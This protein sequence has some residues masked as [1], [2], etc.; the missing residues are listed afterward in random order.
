MTSEIESKIEKVIEKLEKAQIDRNYLP[1]ANETQEGNYRMHK[2]I[3]GVVT[4]ANINV[5]RFDMQP[6]SNQAPI[7]ESSNEKSNSFTEQISSD[8]L[9]QSLPKLNL[10]RRQSIILDLHKIINVGEYRIELGK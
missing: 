3:A 10:N 5:S 2:R 8:V 6:E 7:N 4:Q 9:D 1:R